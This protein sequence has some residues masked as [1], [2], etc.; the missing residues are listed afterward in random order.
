MTLIEFLHILEPLFPHWSYENDL[1]LLNL[2][3]W[4]RSG[5]SDGEEAACNAGNLGSIPG[6]GRFPGGGNSNL[7]QYFCLGNPMDRGAWWTTVHGVAKSQTLLS[8]QA[9]KHAHTCYNNDH[10]HHPIIVP[11]PLTTPNVTIS[12]TIQLELLLLLLSIQLP[13]LTCYQSI[14]KEISPE[15]SLEGLG[16][17]LKL[18]YFGHLMRGTDSLKKTLMLGKI[19]GRRRRG[20]QRM[21]WL[22][23]ITDSMDMGVSKLWELV[24][25]REA[26]CAAVHGVVKSWTQLNDWTEPPPAT[27]EVVAI[28]AI[29]LTRY[30]VLC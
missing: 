6:L 18:Q 15:Y 16:L 29:M 3:K 8:N 1:S 11:P 14:L 26:W 5:G 28:E 25:D 4:G 10:L 21:R 12:T 22:D 2:G 23:G 13:P 19:E 24:L 9:C 17:K 30:Q 20:W 27:I 7:L